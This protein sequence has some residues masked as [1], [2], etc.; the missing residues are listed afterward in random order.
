M[1]VPI[2]IK[3]DSEARRESAHSHSRKKSLISQA[4]GKD[5]YNIHWYAGWLYTGN[6]PFLFFWKGR[7]AGE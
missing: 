1:F 7:R 2:Q 6:C 3:S 5:S 4:A